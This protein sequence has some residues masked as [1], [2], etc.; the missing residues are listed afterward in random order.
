MR[1]GKFSLSLIA[2]L[3]GMAALTAPTASGD[4]VNAQTAGPQNPS[5]A[6]NAGALNVSCDTGTGVL[7]GTLELPAAKPPFP[8]ALLIAGSGPTDR[9]GNSPMLP[10]KNDA[11][12]M[13]AQALAARGIASLRYDKRAIAASKAAGLKEADLRFDIYVDDAVRWGQQL[14]KDGRFNALVIA[15]HSEGSL[16]GML[17]A[18][19]LGASGYVSIAGPGRPAATIIMEQV[20][21]QPIGPDLLKQVE[22]VVKSLE[23]GRQ[24]E[25]VPAAL[26]PMLRPSVQPYLIS[27]FKYDPAREIAKLKMPVLILQ[28]TT[29]IQVSVNDAKLLA[30]ALPAAKLVMLDGINHV[31]KEAPADRAKQVASYSDPS[32]PVSPRL[33]EE[34]IGFINGLKPQK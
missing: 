24:V 5:G 12:K 33:L 3:I 7:Y 25:P 18:Q 14:R 1:L 6:Q 21:A 34:V 31:L 20:R 11:L 17:A 19:K 2:L 32:L 27:W 10:G 16:I 28:G 29:D 4:N 15:G 9:D 26:A 23:E 30:S 22:D 13:I 8:I